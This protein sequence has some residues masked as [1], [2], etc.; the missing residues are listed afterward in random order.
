MSFLVSA[1]NEIYR[2]KDDFLFIGLTGRTGSGCSAVAKLLGSNFDIFQE[3]IY[4]SLS[5]NNYR[6]NKIL[7]K[8]LEKNW[9]RFNVIQVR[10]VITLILSQEDRRKLKSFL[11]DFFGNDSSLKDELLS[12]L[13]KIRRIH[14]NVACGKTDYVSFYERTLPEICEKIR[15][16][17]GDDKFVALY[18]A[19][20]KNLRSSGST[21]IDQELPDK[22]FTLAR[23][24][25]E[26]CKK[27][28]DENRGN[29][30][31]TAIVVDAIRS[32]LEAMYFQDRYASFYLMAISC[33]EAERKDRLNR[34]GYSPEGIASIDKL[35]GTG[36]LLHK[37]SPLSW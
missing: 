7:Y 2:K 16:A 11:T 3:S 19:I 8:S 33:S 30:R 20:G 12:H 14:T 18:Q 22:F 6:K 26:I 31:K 25:E 13:I 34:L 1:L 5:G 24:V 23:R 21:V 17:L 9:V 15:S 28:R 36:A 29:N 32:P 37:A 27:I 35:E 4:T 10:S